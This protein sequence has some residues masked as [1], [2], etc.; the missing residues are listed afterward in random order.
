MASSAPVHVLDELE[1]LRH[2]KK[3]IDYCCSRGQDFTYD[4]TK[5]LQEVEAKDFAQTFSMDIIVLRLGHIVDGIMKTDLHGNNLENVNYCRGG[6]V[7]KHDVAKAFEKALI[8]KLHGYNLFYVIGAYQ[9]AR[10]FDN[11]STENILGFVCDESF[12]EY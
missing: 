3:D 7:C 12:S 6:W 11:R 1:H 9:S 10:Y 4:L 8:S 2:D 5:H